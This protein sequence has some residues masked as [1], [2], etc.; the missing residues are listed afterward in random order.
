MEARLPEDAPSFAVVIPMFN[1]EAGAEACVR[2]VTATLSGL[3]GRHCLIVVNDAS[4]DRTGQILDGL[5]PQIENLT[6]LRHVANAGYGAALST[7]VRH[8][9]AGG[10]EYTLFMDSD[11]TNSPA[12][13]PRFVEKMREGHDVIKATRYSA[14]GRV[15]GVPGYRVIISRIGNFVAG[16][17]FRLPLRDC[18]NGFRAVRTALLERMKLTEKR[19]PI[20]MEELYWSKY[21]A[22][23]YAEIPVIL[24]ERRADIRRTSFTYRPSVFWRYLK[25]PLRAFVGVRPEMN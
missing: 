21:L 4:T 1:E 3:P 17:L 14:G 6:V 8:A 23:R 12:D 5:A 15:I 10:Y 9:A 11:L 24:T 25:Y 22:R 16:R 20:I 7:G 19:F 18:T 13:L 2:E